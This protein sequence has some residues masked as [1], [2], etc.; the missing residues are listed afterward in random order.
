M[1]L[2]AAATAATLLARMA[3]LNPK[4]AFVYGDAPR[5]RGD[6]IVSVSLGGSRRNLLL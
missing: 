5:A 2:L 1:N 4:P 3:A 6:E